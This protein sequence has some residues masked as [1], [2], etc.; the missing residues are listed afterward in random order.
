MGFQARRDHDEM[1]VVKAWIGTAQPFEAS[2]QEAGNDQQETAHSYLSPKKNGA[3]SAG[4]GHQAGEA[5][6][7]RQPKNQRGQERIDE[8]DGEHSP[9]REKGGGRIRL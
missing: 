8:R 9:I 4:S 5:E 3:G 2:D 7:R 1:A 6:G